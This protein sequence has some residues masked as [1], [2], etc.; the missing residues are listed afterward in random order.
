[1]ARADGGVDSAFSMEPSEFHAL[2]VECDRAW[3]AIGG[4]AFGGTPAEE[5]SR[6]FRRSLYIA[7]DMRAGDIL[8]PENLRAIRP[9]YGLPPK[10]LTQLLGQRVAR[11]V[12]RGTAASWDLFT[13][14]D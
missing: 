2:R 8:T 11:D 5:G 7:S 13:G 10:Y 14:A 4:I 9:G 1:L 6:T 12:A 3:Q